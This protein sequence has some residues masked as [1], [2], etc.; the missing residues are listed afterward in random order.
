MAAPAP[1]PRVGIDSFAQL[2]VPLP[3]PYDEAAAA[4]AQVA[5]A[6]ARARASGK[7]LLIDLGGDWCGDCQ[8]LTATMDRPDQWASTPSVT[9]ADGSHPPPLGVDREARGAEPPSG[10]VGGASRSL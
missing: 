2:K 3:Y 7:L 4:D 8:I 6:K 5:R 1:A 10:S 9:F